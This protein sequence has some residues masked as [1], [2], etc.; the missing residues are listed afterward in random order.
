[1]RSQASGTNLT[2]ANANWPS[3]TGVNYSVKWSGTPILQ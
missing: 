1:M 2:F 3:A